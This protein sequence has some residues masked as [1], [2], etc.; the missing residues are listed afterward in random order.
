MRVYEGFCD[1][2][3]FLAASGSPLLF[4]MQLKSGQSFEVRLPR[5]FVSDLSLTL[6]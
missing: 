1:G 5:V 6:R 4:F 2:F 3:A